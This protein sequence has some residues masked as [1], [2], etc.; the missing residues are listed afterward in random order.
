MAIAEKLDREAWLADNSAEA[1]AI[2][3]LSDP[4]SK[5][6]WIVLPETT[7]QEYHSSLQRLKDAGY[8]VNVPVKN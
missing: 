3:R 6:D 5:K 7:D 2:R 8:S 4:T 1:K